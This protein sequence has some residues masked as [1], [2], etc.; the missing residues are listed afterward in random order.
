MSHPVNVSRQV[1]PVPAFE[2]TGG[3]RRLTDDGRSTEER[4]K[5]MLETVPRFQMSGLNFL[6]MLHIPPVAV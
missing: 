6:F 3:R 4:E 2:R 5:G 1:P